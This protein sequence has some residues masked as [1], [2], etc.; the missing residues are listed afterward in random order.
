MFVCVRARKGTD[1]DGLGAV[2]LAGWMWDVRQIKIVATKS[3]LH[4]VVHP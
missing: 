2:V 4:E 1:L 3:F